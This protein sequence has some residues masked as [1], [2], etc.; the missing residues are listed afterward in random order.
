MSSASM[1]GS[2]TSSFCTA[3]QMSLSILLPSPRCRGGKPQAP[4]SHS[5]GPTSPACSSRPGLGRNSMTGSRATPRPGKQGFYSTVCGSLPLLRCLAR[6]LAMQLVLQ[7]LL[8]LLGQGGLEDGAAVLGQPIHGLVR[9]HLLDH[10]EQRRRAGL[11]HVADLVLEGLIDTSL[12][13]VPYECPY[14]CPNS[15]A[16]EWDEKEEP[17]EESPEQPPGGALADRVM[18][19]DGLDVAIL[20][21]DDRGDRV[22]L[23][24]QVLRESLN[25]LFRLQS[26]CGVRVSDRDEI[27]HVF[28]PPKGQCRS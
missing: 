3:A 23:D 28:D 1:R 19:R 17:E 26:G 11:Q 18:V 14:T 10:H 15:H 12:A 4:P 13:D 2:V 22:R 6:L 25:F 7:L 24:H 20:V 27:C 5:S 21:A 16:K 9:G 8:G